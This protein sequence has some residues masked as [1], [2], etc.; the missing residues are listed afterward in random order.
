MR[1][2]FRCLVTVELQQI[3]RYAGHCFAH[4]AGLGVDE[5]TDDRHEWRYRGSEQSGPGDRDMAWTGFI[6]HQ[7]DRIRP[8]ACSGKRILHARDAANFDS[9]H[10]DD[11]LRG[12]GKNG[13]V[14][15]YGCRPNPEH[16]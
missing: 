6:E 5:Q 13:I 8:A 9:G 16:W 4:Q 14:K 10:V 1:A 12:I 7:A 2:I 11:K 15:H 3:Q